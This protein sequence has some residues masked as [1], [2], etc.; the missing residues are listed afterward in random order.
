M[1]LALGMIGGVLPDLDSDSSKPVQI[2]FKILAIFLPLLVLLL[3]PQ[4]L[5][6]L[7]MLG[8]WLVSTFVLK[9][10]FTIFFLKMTT[11]RGIFHTIPMG[12]LFAQLLILL[13]HYVFEFDLK[14]STIAGTFLFF[15]FVLH[16]ILDE[17]VSLNILGLRVKNSF[18][19]AFKIYD[20]NNIYG[21]LVLY[22][23]I[24][25]LYYLMPFSNDI[26]VSIFDLLKD[27]RFI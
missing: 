1:I 4:K 10:L 9:L 15:G 17:L 21:T 22:I 24:I 13:F 25:T 19:T 6:I 5:P 8:I 27:I 23:S 18:G 2:V 20:V 16:L 12:I 26:Y 3:M 11:H 14:F 7:H